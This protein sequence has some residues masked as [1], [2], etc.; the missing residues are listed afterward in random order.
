M[1]G[2]GSDDEAWTSQAERTRHLRSQHWS[3]PRTRFLARGV[4]LAVEV[5]ATASRP[6]CGL[7]R[8]ARRGTPQ[9]LPCRSMLDQP[10]A[11]TA[12]G[13][14][15]P[16]GRGDEA[17]R[18]PALPEQNGGSAGAVCSSSLDQA[19]P[20]A[21]WKARISIRSGL[22]SQCPVM[23]LPVRGWLCGS[24]GLFT[25]GRPGGRWQPATAGG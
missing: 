23:P 11:P 4:A 25:A 8:R 17:T 10:G 1:G 24:A 14:R 7:P 9:R 3:C 12:R 6:P 19:T 22:P 5:C 21:T 13:P 20:A 2:S 18:G 16:F 15:R